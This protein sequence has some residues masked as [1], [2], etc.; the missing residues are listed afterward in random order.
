MKKFLCVSL[1]ALMLMG[2]C[3]CGN[4][5]D[6]NQ[7]AVTEPKF[8]ALATD[9]DIALLDGLYKDRKAYFGDM[10]NHSESMGRSD[11]HI[12]LED[13]PS[14]VM[15]PK[16]M[17]FAVLV[18]HKQSE[19]MRLPEWDDTLFV[20]GSEAGTQ[21][22]DPA[23]EQGNMHYN[24]IF[25]DPDKLDQYVKSH[26]EYNYRLDLDPEFKDRHPA[27]EDG[28]TDWYC[29]SYPTF[30][31]EL[32]RERMAEI[33]DL[34]GF[35]VQVHPLFNN[36]I[37]SVDP[38][39]YWYSDYS[40][41]EIYTSTSHDYTPA[42]E[43]MIKAKATW[44][45]LLNLGKI[46]FATC[47]SDDHRDSSVDSLSTLYSTEKHANAYLERMRVGDF[48]AGPVGIR[49]A[50]GDV[51]TGGQTDFAGKRLVISVADWHPQAIKKDSKYRL[52]I[53][54]DKGLVGSVDL[55]GTDPVYFAIDAEDC[56][57]YRAEVWDVTNDYWFAV[58]NPIWNSKYLN[59]G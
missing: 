29:F 47:G 36:Y 50:M 58:G 17:D 39:G 56:K 8:E 40:G 18:D 25:T 33:Y 51:V 6:T 5:A 28:R 3:A 11:G 42:H 43:A 24:M 53:Y 13:W 9:A 55:N 27:L 48:T 19:H 54:N 14:T 22:I 15:E 1:A 52:D 59:Q 10:H 21:I 7:P 35:Y 2:L 46:V 12:K 31:P 20:G 57:Y 23:L 16:Q 38:L 26:A 49:M 37:K 4:A 30:S 32:F 45:E 44:V 41:F 34:G